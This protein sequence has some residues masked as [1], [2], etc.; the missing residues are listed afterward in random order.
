MCDLGGTV[1]KIMKIIF[2]IIYRKE[3]QSVREQILFIAQKQAKAKIQK[4]MTRTSSQRDA[5]HYGEIFMKT[6]SVVQYG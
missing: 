2:T 1:I 6:F 4:E 3:P 5:E